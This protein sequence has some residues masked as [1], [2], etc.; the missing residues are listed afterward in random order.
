MWEPGWFRLHQVQQPKQQH[1]TRHGQ[2]GLYSVFTMAAFIYTD[3]PELASLRAMAPTLNPSGGA[4]DLGA[5]V[6]SALDGLVSKLSDMVHANETSHASLT[7]RIASVESVTERTIG[8]HE[9]KIGEL[10]NVG[11]ASR[12]R[13][14][15]ALQELLASTSA[16][17]KAIDE[18]LAGFTARFSGRDGGPGGPACFYAE[19][20]RCRPNPIP[21]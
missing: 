10:Y 8:V 7:A 9:A 13:I 21:H 15:S 17:F 5:A 4:R 6:V 3:P 19:H 14:D 1:R 2:H 20:R 16:K 12:T 18:S 11:Q